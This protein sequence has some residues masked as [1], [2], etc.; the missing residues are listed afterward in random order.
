MSMDAQEIHER[1]KQHLGAGLIE[2]VLEA[3]D[4]WVLVEPGALVDGCLLLGGQECDCARQ[5]ATEQ[6]RLKLLD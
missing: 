4:P 6:V 5:S 3:K 2:S 1:V